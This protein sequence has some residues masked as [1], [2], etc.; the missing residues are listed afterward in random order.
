MIRYF[1]IR[2]FDIS[3]YRSFQVLSFRILTPTPK[4]ISFL[5]IGGQGKRGYFQG[6]Y[7]RRLRI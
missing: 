7:S 5:R 3:K 6:F 1:N 2:N 4:C